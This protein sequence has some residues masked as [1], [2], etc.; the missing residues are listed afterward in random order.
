VPVLLPIVSTCLIY[1]YT[2]VT[3]SVKTVRTTPWSRGE[4]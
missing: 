4:L 2:G 3:V 1:D